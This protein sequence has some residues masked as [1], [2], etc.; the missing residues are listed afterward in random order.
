MCIKSFFGNYGC[1]GF[2]SAAVINT[3]AQSSVG[4]KKLISFTV[5][6]SILEGSRKETEIRGE[7]TSW[8]GLISG[9]TT[10]VGVISY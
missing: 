5:A 10:D 8:F 9:Y 1:P 7:A 2:L 6:K 3:V 4:R